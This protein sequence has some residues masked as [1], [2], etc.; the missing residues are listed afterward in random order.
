[1]RDA[2]DGKAPRARPFS[3]VYSC[4]PRPAAVAC[5][6]LQRGMREEGPA[7][8]MRLLIV[9]DD[10]DSR[11]MLAQLFRMND[12]EVMEVSTTDDAIAELRIGGVDVVISDEDLEG[13]S[14]SCMLRTASAEGL[15][16]NVGALMYTA[17]PE[18]LMVPAG[19]RVFR[20]PLGFSRLLDEAKAVAVAPPSSRRRARDPVELV[21]Y[22]TSSPSSA[23]ALRTL[24]SVLQDTHPRRV[25]VI[26]HNLEHDVPSEAPVSFRPGLVQR[27]PGE[28][29]RFFGSPDSTRSLAALIE[30]LD[31]Q[32]PASS[33]AASW[34]A[35]PSSRAGRR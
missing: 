25:S 6:V 2:F 33:Q 30:E 18:L 10:P 3:K 19:V 14:G 28:P 23:R 5:A 1:M 27:R 31:E 34:G 15:L 4:V 8:E 20:K 12:W 7:H 35:P 22:V 26:V 11:E 29:E 32:E 9:E 16:R 21:L 17:E 24:Q 13:Q